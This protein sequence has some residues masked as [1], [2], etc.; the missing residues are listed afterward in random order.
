[1]LDG[2][3]IKSMVLHRVGAIVPQHSHRSAHLSMLAVGSVRVWRDDE[4]LGD[5]KAPA[6][7]LIE[8]SSKHRFLTLTD[9][10]LIYCIHAT[11]DPDDLVEEQNGL[12]EFD[13]D[14]LKG[15]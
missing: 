9:E 6:G 14:I 2:L 8:A 7:I 13:F 3:F 10:V 1:M 4:L 11:T 15:L 5:F 12:T